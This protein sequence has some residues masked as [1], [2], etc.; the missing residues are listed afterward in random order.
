MSTPYE[1][2]PGSKSA[3]EVQREGHVARR[4]RRGHRGDFRS[5]SPPASCSTKPWPT[6][7][8]ASGQAFMRNLGATVR[9]NPVPMVLMSTG[10]GLADVLGPALPEGATSTREDILGRLCP[11]GQLLGAGDYPA[12]YYPRRLRPDWRRRRLSRQS[13]ST[14]CRADAARRHEPG[15]RAGTLE[16]GKAAAEQARVRSLGPA[17]GARE[18]AQRMERR[19]TLGGG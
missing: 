1:T 13:P 14:T 6:C 9:D 18:T 17:E 19:S 16:G 11:E 8:A 2:D 10:L 12:G 5:A 7:G 3:E 15:R 4:G